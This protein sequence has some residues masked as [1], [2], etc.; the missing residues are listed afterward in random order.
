MQSH[1]LGGWIGANPG[2]DLKILC[3]DAFHARLPIGLLG[4]L[5]F[6]MW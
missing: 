5:C 4:G 2:P 1:G 3:G 6:L